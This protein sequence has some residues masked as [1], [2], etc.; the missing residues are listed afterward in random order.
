M[1]AIGALVCHAAGGLILTFA[2][3]WL[4]GGMQMSKSKNPPE[5]KF[6]VV[7]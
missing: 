2:R 1:L 6:L 4:V 3:P 5:S 7:Q